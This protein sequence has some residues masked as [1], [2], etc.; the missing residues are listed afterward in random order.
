MTSYALQKEEHLSKRDGV[1][2]AIRDG[3][4]RFT[5]I[6]VATGMSKRTLTKVLS[7]L[8]NDSL[9]TKDGEGQKIRYH[10]TNRATETV[11]ADLGAFRDIS[12]AYEKWHPSLTT[13]DG[14]NLA[15]GSIAHFPIVQTGS[16]YDTSMNAD[17]RPAD[18]FVAGAPEIEGLIHQ[19][20]MEWAILNGM[21]RYAK[22]DRKKHGKQ[23]IAVVVDYDWLQELW[24]MADDFENAITRKD[25]MTLFFS[26]S[27]NA[28]PHEE[29]F[30]MEA[31]KV[32]MWGRGYTVPLGSRQER[33]FN[34]VMTLLPAM[35]KM[36]LMPI[37]PDIDLSPLIK[38]IGKAID[39]PFLEVHDKYMKE[40][41][42]F[43]YGWKELKGDT[44]PAKVKNY[45]N[46]KGIS[47]V[48]NEDLMEFMGFYLLV[49]LK[50]EDLGFVQSVL[51]NWGTPFAFL[52]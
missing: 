45:L 47:R 12:E 6:L 4:H 31:E 38:A 44:F 1:L 23:R 32:G 26:K 40:R 9:V 17:N 52:G 20:V 13:H 34:I 22:G 15:L 2:R 33:A 43:M 51:K 27:L 46:A 49:S 16:I 39:G 28:S 24:D 11:K 30:Q 37:D 50:M 3:R 21:G 5:E 19:D 29:A 25:G 14:P 41:G 7:E 18:P 48:S 10:L 42:D 8:A 35:L 36:I